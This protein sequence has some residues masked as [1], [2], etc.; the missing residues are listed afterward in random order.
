MVLGGGAFLLSEVPLQQIWYEFRKVDAMCN[1]RVQSVT[2]RDAQIG[3]RLEITRQNT[4]SLFEQGTSL[5]SA[6]DWERGGDEDR[7]RILSQTQC[8]KI[9]F[10]KVMSP[11]N[12]S[13]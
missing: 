10:S 7:L 11:T 2:K 8:F 6:H 13:T 9:C 3:F 12:L 4:P 5:G 1:S